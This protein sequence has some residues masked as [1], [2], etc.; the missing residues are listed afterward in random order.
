MIRLV[1][2][3]IAKRR[4]S[5]DLLLEMGVDAALLQECHPS[6]LKDDAKRGRL[7]F[8]PYRPWHEERYDRW[9]MIVRL[10]DRVRIQWFRQVEPFS[11]VGRAEM[12]VSGVGIIEAARLF[13]AGSAAP[14]IVASIYARWVRPHPTA[15]SKW[16]VGYQDGSAHGAITDLSAF[17]GHK[18]PGTHRILAAGDFNTI[19]GATDDNRLAL[20]ARDNTIFRRMNALGLEFLGPQHP[21]GR[22]T[23][24]V[25]HGLPGDTGNVPTYHSTRQSPE[26]AA[27]QLDY[28][29]ASRGFHQEVYVQAL[30]EVEEWGPSDH[31]R[32]LIEVGDGP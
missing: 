30:N 18:D 6:L 22:K 4:A 24:P 14:F 15:N 16:G 2:W 13:P 27:N 29:F 23:V 32:L 9:P 8:N 1:S 3:N 17:I 11:V 21:Q 31:C 10:S 25:P 20:P 12:S 7:E 19:R 5:V 28:A 26:T